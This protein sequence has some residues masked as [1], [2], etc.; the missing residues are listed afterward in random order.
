MG[1]LLV[2]NGGTL[3]VPLAQVIASGNI[4]MPSPGGGAG[5]FLEVGSP[6]G[7][8]GDA[9]HDGIVNALD[10][11]LV[12]AN[13]LTTNPNKNGPGDLN[14][15]GIVNGEDASAIASHWLQVPGPGAAPGPG[16]S[17]PGPLYNVLGGPQN[18]DPGAFLNYATNTIVPEPSTL[19][20]AAL[21]AI[22]LLFYRH[23]RLGSRSALR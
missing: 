6:P 4:A 10:L 21:G 18:I 1:D 7:V 12:A 13:W 15:D 3:T 17:N 5:T 11:A 22:A 2:A 23:R 20:L 16:P 8:T 9:N 19:I 14:G